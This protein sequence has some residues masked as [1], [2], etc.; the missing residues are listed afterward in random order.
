[1]ERL[2]G[3]YASSQ[4]ME[5]LISIYDNYSEFNFGEEAPESVTLLMRRENASWAR[6]LAVVDKSSFFENWK[7]LTCSMFDGMNW[8]NVFVAGGAVLACLLPGKLIS[9]VSFNYQ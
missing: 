8:S 9:I 5:L 1:M 4:G 6:S 3:E 2:E 7:A